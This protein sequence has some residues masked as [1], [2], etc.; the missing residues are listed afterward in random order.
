M[1]S[2]EI[3]AYAKINLSLDVLGKRPDG[4][5]DVK[6]IMQQIDLFDEV[7]VTESEEKGIRIETNLHCLPVDSSNI[8][9]KAAQMIMDEYRIE[10]GLKITIKKNIPVAAGLAG[11][12]TDAA[13]VLKGLNEMWQLNM[14][15]D[16]LM[17]RGRQLGA[18]VPFCILGGCALAEGIGEILTPIQG[19]D[20]LVVLSK[21]PI[22]VSSGAVYQK[23]DLKEVKEHPDTDVLISAI[24]ENR[25]NDIPSNMVNV[26][27]NVTLK[28][29]PI[30]MYTKNIMTQ[31]DP[32]AAIMSGSGPTVFGIFNNREKA[33][34]AYQK[35]LKINKD[36]FLVKM[37]TG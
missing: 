20:F 21:P 16:E 22:G 11:G 1:K 9:Y 27:E 34:Y 32:I 24:K 13:A 10:K 6:M 7:K 25:I 4:Y 3:K 37:I 15:L 31:C 12:S 29:Y 23:L 36:T 33:E 14:T 18:D 28:E 19:P 17:K 8:A 2:M 30:V 26:L 5:H 35:L